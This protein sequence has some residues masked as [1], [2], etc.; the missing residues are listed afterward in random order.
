MKTRDGFV[1]NSSSSSFIVRLQH[2]AKFLQL[3]VSE[4]ATSEDVVKLLDFGFR[5]VLHIHPSHLEEIG[6]FQYDA[7]KEILEETEA[8]GYSV[9]CNQDD[10][11][12]FL[13]RNDIPF[14]AA[15]HYG[16]ESVFYRRG[17]DSVLYIR[18]PGLER[19]TYGD[20]LGDL[21]IGDVIRRELK[22]MS[23]EE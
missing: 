5:P 8:L 9:I 2:L 22:V 20:L 4:V 14:M 10:V 11:I 12:D 7:P 21:P 23:Y 3:K 13:V 1:S 19:E 17:D 18:N 16:H 15:C 6:D